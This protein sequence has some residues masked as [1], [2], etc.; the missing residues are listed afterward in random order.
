MAGAARRS[1]GPQ[2]SVPMLRAG[3][4]QAASDAMLHDAAA[5][6]YS[7]LLAQPLIA[8]ADNESVATAADVASNVRRPSR[9]LRSS[10]VCASGCNGSCAAC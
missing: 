3:G 7:E 6:Q 5:A 9:H 8:Q 4:A 2:L 10:P 1:Y